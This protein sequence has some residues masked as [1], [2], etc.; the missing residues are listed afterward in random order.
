MLHSRSKTVQGSDC[1]DGGSSGEIGKN[2]R[3]HVHDHG[4]TTSLQRDRGTTERPPVLSAI[5]K[6]QCTELGRQCGNEA[7]DILGGAGICKG[8]MNFIANKFQSMP[9]RL[10]WRVQHVDKKSHRVW[11]GSESSDP[12]MQDLIGSIWPETMVL[13]SSSSLQAFGTCGHQRCSKLHKI[14]DKIKIQVRW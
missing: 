9:V 10:P 8:P 13:I 4:V 11:T 7:M 3:Q 5:M 14:L 12:Q 2:L 6:L 1:R